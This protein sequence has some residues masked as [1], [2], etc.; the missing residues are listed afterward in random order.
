MKPREI[1]DLTVEEIER[2]IKENKEMLLKLNLKLSTKQ[3][4]NTSQIRQIKRDI[5]RLITVLKEKKTKEAVK[6]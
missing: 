5:A 1:R 6:G 2:K 3:M 4:E